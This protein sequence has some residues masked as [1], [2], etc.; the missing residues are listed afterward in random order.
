VH[1]NNCAA[2]PPTAK[3]QK[4]QE[5][6]KK[7]A[8][9]AEGKKSSNGTDFVVTDKGEAIPIPKNATGPSAPQRGTGMVYQGGS[10]GK[11]M[12]KKTT[13]VRIMDANNN[14]GR[15]V[16]YMN[17]TDQTVDPSSGR[18]ISNSDPRGHLPLK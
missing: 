15:R 5:A 14:Q 17:K 13:G 6:E 7:L 4:W 12:D 18:T 11:G 9:A 16:N 3:S 10:G 1:N 8:K 2:K